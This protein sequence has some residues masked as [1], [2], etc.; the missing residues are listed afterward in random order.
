WGRFS[1]GIPGPRSATSMHS[2]S[3]SV[4]EESETI[5]P[6]GPYFAALS[7]RISTACS[8]CPGSTRSF[9]SAT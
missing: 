6:V 9:P 3:G 7:A 4:V 8:I 5:P 2:S 1:S